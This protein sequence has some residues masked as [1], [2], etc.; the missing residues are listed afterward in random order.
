MGPGSAGTL[1]TVEEFDALEIENCDELYRY[2]LIHEVLVVSPPPSLHER[3]PNDQLL[4][5][6]LIYKETHPQGSALDAT[7]NEHTISTSTGRR[8]ADRAIWAGL[9][10]KVNPRT[11][12]PAIA[13]EFVSPGKRNWRR[14]DVENRREYLEVG[15]REYWRIDRFR[16]TMT[17][18]RGDGEVEVGD[19][20][21]YRTDL[22]P[23]FELPMARLFAVSERWAGTDEG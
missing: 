12:I 14:D 9:G 7:V 21:V 13:V 5:L 20:E 19:R 18:Y 6:L 2:E 3:D 8:R 15:V 16:R 22:L 4:Y 11:D 23:G 1:T 10:R 17:V